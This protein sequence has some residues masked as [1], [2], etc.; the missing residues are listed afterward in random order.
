[1]KVAIYSRGLDIEQENPLLIL[2]E[3]LNRHDTE[4]LLFNTLFEQFNIPQ[5]LC[6]K[7]Q[8]FSGYEDLGE[9]VD[10]VISLGGDGT[11]L[12]TITLIREKNIPVLGINFGRLGFL[13]SISREELATA[14]DAL[15]NHTFIIDKRTLI[16][17]DSNTPLFAD[18]PFALNE[19]TIH[20]KDTSPMIKIHT[21]MNGEF[22]NTYW[23]DGLIVSTPTGSTGY[24]LSCNGPIL[25]PDSSSL[26]ITPICPHNLNVRSIVIPDNNIIS[27]EVEGRA[28][29]F[30]VAMDARRE[31]VPK[32]VQLAVRKEA[33]NISLIRLNE[34]TF[35]STLR[36]KLTWGLDKRN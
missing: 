28:D 33:F 26:V 1:M 25:F 31:L 9:S 12:D 3:E 21:Y 17:L 15:V 13:A 23:A 29:E 11:M 22:L 4:I 8:H 18:A 34:N 30:I 10:C 20:K 32:S 7:I 19:F 24:N 6:N 27:F 16:H 36:T 35:L 2:L 14:V 5:E